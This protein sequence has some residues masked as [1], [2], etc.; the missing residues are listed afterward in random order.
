MPAWSNHL[1][2][3]S[4]AQ[5]SLAGQS[6]FSDKDRSSPLCLKTKRDTWPRACVLRTRGQ[7]RPSRPSMLRLHG[8]AGSSGYRRPFCAT[9]AGSPANQSEMRRGALCLY[10]EEGALL[11][12]RSA[13]KSS[14]SCQCRCA[15]IRLGGRTEGATL[16]S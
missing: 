8:D 10:N 4:V 7:L 6:L 9:A 5:Q 16:G 1:P 14:P 2:D 15:D 12:R 3:Q 11:A 13:S